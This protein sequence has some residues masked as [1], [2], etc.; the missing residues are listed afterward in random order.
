MHKLV[1]KLATTTSVDQELKTE[2]TEGAHARISTVIP[3]TCF[4]IMRE[5]E[6]SVLTS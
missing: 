4:L 3:P 2:V 6:T 5:S 1:I